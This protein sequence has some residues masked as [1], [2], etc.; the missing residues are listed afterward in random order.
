MLPLGFDEQ[1]YF[2]AAYR[3]KVYV[4]GRVAQGSLNGPNIFGRLSALTG[5]ITQGCFSPADLRLQIYADDPCAVV[6]G[7]MANRRRMVATVLMLW[8][9]MGYTLAYHKGQLGRKLTW[10][11]YQLELAEEF[12]R[13]SIKDA[14]MKDFLADTQAMSKTN[15]IRV[16]ALRRFTGQ[17]NHISGLLFAWRPFLDSLWAALSL[18]GSRKGRAKHGFVWKRQVKPSLDWFLCFL[19]RQKS[20]LSRQWWYSS[21]HADA[22]EVSMILDASPYGYG[23]VLVING[24]VMAYFAD[25]ISRH[26]VRIMQTEAGNSKGQQTWEALALLVAV[27]LWAPWWT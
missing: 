2:S 13:V 15:L 22:A 26:D 7:S 9:C 12:I 8:R 16:R 20:H 10:I 4:W 21:Y 27:K 14:F 24:V 19:I 6:R 3:G 5:R 23:G 1:P 11:G 17:A 18:Q 25:T